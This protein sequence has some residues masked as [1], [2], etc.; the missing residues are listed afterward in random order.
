[1]SL[2][3]K[4]LQDSIAESTQE[5]LSQL[6]SQVEKPQNDQ[7]EISQNETGFK[8]IGESKDKKYYIYK[9][10]IPK[11]LLVP[12][13]MVT[14]MA[15]KYFWK[16]YKNIQFTDST[17]REKKGNLKG[18]VYL[19]I[20][21]KESVDRLSGKNVVD[22]TPEMTQEDIKEIS[23]EQIKDIFASY[24][25]NEWSKWSKYE[26]EDKY[27]KYVIINSKKL[28]IKYQ[29]RGYNPEFKLPK[30]P[31]LFV[32]YDD[33]DVTY[34][35]IGQWDWKN[36]NWAECRVFKAEFDKTNKKYK[37][38][39]EVERDNKKFENNWK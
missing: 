16:V 24:V 12:K 35:L 30:K 22:T 4:N 11:W 2:E 13:N 39:Y 23:D 3:T 31:Y 21:K 8:Y 6:K 5:E 15:N 32:Q 34:I 29:Y 26:K 28:Y 20:P 27:G 14:E 19:R 17:W 7:V 1:M 25:W 9:H 33:G 36:F 37:F 18:D 10:T 38:E